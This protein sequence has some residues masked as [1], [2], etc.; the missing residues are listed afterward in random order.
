MSST[1]TPLIVHR[2]ML[3]NDADPFIVLNQQQPVTYKAPLSYQQPTFT[4]F[5]AQKAAKPKYHYT[6]E[7][8]CSFPY[9]PFSMMDVIIASRK[10]NRIGA[11][12][13]VD[14]GA[15][16]NVHSLTSAIVWWRAH[17]CCT[18]SLVCSYF[19]CLLLSWPSLV[20]IQVM[21]WLFL[22][23]FTVVCHFRL[24]I[25]IQHNVTM[26]WSPPCPLSIELNTS[27]VSINCA[28]ELA[29]SII[30]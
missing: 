25:S 23:H 5:S 13:G 1:V 27:S 21:A 22:V 4:R 3:Q 14:I 16:D 24:K 9:S 6:V 17:F 30:V 7:Q 2:S 26:E 29:F 19:C 18:Y 20:Y 28:W 10:G 11:A 8:V 15:P 12:N